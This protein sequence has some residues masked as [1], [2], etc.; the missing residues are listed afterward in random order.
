[1]S[2]GR[3]L[4]HFRKDRVGSEDKCTFVATHLN[5]GGGTKVLPEDHYINFSAPMIY[6]GGC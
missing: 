6:L 3:F 1:M 2:F 5:H 4:R